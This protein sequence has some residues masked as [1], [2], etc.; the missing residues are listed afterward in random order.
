MTSSWRTYVPNVPDG[1]SRRGTS[2][3]GHL[4]VLIFPPSKEQ[5]KRGDFSR[6]FAICD[7]GY[8][9]YNTGEPLKKAFGSMLYSSPEII[10]GTGHFST[11]TDIWGLGVILYALIYATLP[12]GG[13]DLRQHIAAAHF[14]F[15]AQVP[16]SPDCKALISAIMKINPAERLTIDQIRAHPWLT[17]SRAPLKPILASV[18]QSSSSCS[19]LA[20]ASSSGA[21]SSSVSLSGTADSDCASPAQSA[22][23]STV[24]VIANAADPAAPASRA[25]APKPANNGCWYLDS[26][27]EDLDAV[28][29]Q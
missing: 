5:V 20:S 21:S 4:Q 9:R 29:R 1:W 14:S 12:F 23:L 26:G 15:P 19:P 2:S 3:D 22:Q 28:G 24:C 16:V 27:D 18:P 8:A 11:A 17:G 13:K 10:T 7:W 6:R 25:P